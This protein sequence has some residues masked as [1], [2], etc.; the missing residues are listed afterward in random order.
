MLKRRILAGAAA[1][2]MAA[3]IILTG[4]SSGKTDIKNPAIQAK[5]RYAEGSIPL[6]AREDGEAEGQTLFYQREDGIIVLYQIQYKE[7]GGIEYST[8]ICNKD[9]WEPQHDKRT[10]EIEGQ[11]ESV[12]QSNDGNDYMML[13]DY[14]GYMDDYS[15]LKSVVFQITPD[16]TSSPYLRESI[17][18]ALNGEL[19]DSFF[20]REDGSIIIS[21][22]TQAIYIDKNGNEKTRMRQGNSH[23]MIRTLSAINETDYITYSPERTQLLR[24]RL[25]TGEVEESIEL[26]KISSDRIQGR[27]MAGEDGELYMCDTE[28]LHYWKMGGSVWETFIDGTLN[29][30][31]MPSV[32]ILGIFGGDN[33]D[34]YVGVSGGGAYLPSV[35]LE[36]NE[37]YV[38][39]Y[40]GRD[41][42]Q[43]LHFVYDPDLPSVPSKVLNV[44]G[45]DDFSTIRQAVSVFQK[46]NPDVMVKYQVGDGGSGNATL[47][48]TIKALNTELLNKKGADVIIL[49]GLPVD[50]YIKKGILSDLSGFV[51]PMIENKTI[52]PLISSSWKREDGGIYSVPIR[53]TMPV[54]YGTKEGIEAMSSLKNLLDY[55]E[56]HQEM[57]LLKGLTSNQ[58]SEI[59]M[60]IFHKE[61]FTANGVSEEQL[62]NYL[63][64]VK[65]LQTER[66][67]EGGEED[68]DSDQN[69]YYID[70]KLSAIDY[71]VLSGMFDLMVPGGIITKNAYEV[72]TANSVYYPIQNVGINKASSQQDIAQKFIETLLSEEIQN[73]AFWDGFPVNEASYHS[74]IKSDYSNTMVGYIFNDPNG[75]EYTI[76][77]EWPEEE[78]AERFL[79]IK[80]ELRV[81]TMPERVLESI[82]REEELPYLSGK[83]ELDAAVDRILN[84]VNLYMAE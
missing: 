62:R 76:D 4:C 32:D 18:K 44:Y 59:L 6:P 46:A 39:V 69:L 3:S 53:Y 24:Y 68:P 22:N 72:K 29:S 10:I 84:K 33:N 52:H 38:G 1:F 74:W 73:N 65:L 7:T 14:S 13:T 56:K 83:M 54:L 49:D 60:S 75:E 2:I 82:I 37:E 9:R 61:L 66:T 30:L 17:D 67:E 15:Q 28:G 21:T 55:S 78:L 58:V 5:G 16:G 19:L 63:K 77:G 23:A 71:K 20:I 48:D 27:L 81:P 70:N 40:T 80:N 47:T 43:L 35:E 45:L 34:Y 42:S 36:E 57:P 11:L 64:A 31:S 51:N 26:G 8:Y 25:E 50:D 12:K 41:N 79:Q